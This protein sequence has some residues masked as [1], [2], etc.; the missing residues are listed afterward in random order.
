MYA[1]I[2]YEFWKKRTAVSSACSLSCEESERN[3]HSLV[4]KVKEAGILFDKPKREKPKAV[5]T[6]K[7]ITAVAENV[8]E[9]QWNISE[10]SFR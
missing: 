4:K 6:S 2:A 8:C 1:K 3:W 7:N 5:L 10:T 9:Q